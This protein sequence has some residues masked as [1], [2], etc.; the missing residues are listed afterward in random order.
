MPVR[1]VLSYSFIL[2]QADLPAFLLKPN[3]YDQIDQ[4]YP[5]KGQD[6]AA[7][8]VYQQIAP[9]ERAGS[10]RLVGDPTQREGYQQRDDDRIKDHRRQDSALGTVQ[11]HD[12]QGL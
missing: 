6:D 5:D 3:G 11:V 4:L 7:E 2:S 1:D 9:Q 8:A 12:I 10:D